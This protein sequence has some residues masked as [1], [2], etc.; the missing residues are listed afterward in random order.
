M[1]FEVKTN[2]LCQKNRENR[3]ELKN[4]KPLSEKLNRKIAP[5]IRT[6]EHIELPKA[7]S[8]LLDNGISVFET[9]LG[10]QEVMRLTVV[11]NNAGRTQEHKHAVARATCRLLREGTASFDGAQI[12]EQLD[13]WAGSLRLDGG[14][15][16]STVS[17]HCMTKHF[18]KLMPIIAEMIISPTF[19]AREL[20]TFQKNA[21]QKLQISLTENDTLAF[22]KVSNMM[23]GDAHPYGYNTETAD[24]AALTTEDLARFH[25]ENMTASNAKIYL[26][27][28]ISPS[29]RATLNQYLGKFETKQVEK[30]AD[31]PTPNFT[32]ARA[33]VKNPDTQQTSIYLSRHLFTRKHE[34]YLGMSVLNTIL[35]G[36][37]GS[38]LMS[39]I[40]EEK[41]Y[42]YGIYS[43][44][45][46]MQHA[47]TLNISTDVSNELVKAT[48]KEIY[49]EMN[50]L[51][52][53][54]IL[55]EE[56]VLVKNYL[57]GNMLNVI[58]GAFQVSS[59]IA[60]LHTDGMDETDFERVVEVVK[61]I[62]AADLQ[63][64][65]QRYLDPKDWFQVTAG[66]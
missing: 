22:R 6:I 60:S 52:N 59:L 16:R 46:L 49:F 12:A 53:E 29:V 65:A 61:N 37:F 54:P 23:F 21:S 41:G 8:F 50:R 42:T 5:S 13:F 15:D 64:L 39:N 66:A 33:H 14:F 18:D 1:N 38:R 26:A 7:T 11:F 51:R 31:F 30:A 24:L 45:D 56:L 17:L 44:F 3:M 27:G 43:S 40:R 47:G 48:L 25:A 4:K 9:N 63:Q 10:T 35:G 20:Q 32:P 55:E 62:T 57:L 19:P 2:Y 34:D 58:D 36:Y 28:K